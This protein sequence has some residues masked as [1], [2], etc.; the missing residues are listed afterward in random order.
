MKLICQI[1]AWI[2]FLIGGIGWVPSAVVAEE[3]KSLPSIFKP[4]ISENAMV[5]SQEAVATRVGVA[6]LRSGGNAIDAAVAVG[7]VLAVT[8]PRAGNL[9]GGGFMLVYDAKSGETH[10]IDY[11]ETAPE[12]AK[13]DMFLD[14]GGN[15]DRRKAVGSHL[16]VGVPGTVAGLALALDRFGSM[17]LAKVMQPAIELAAKGIS[18]TRD[19]SQSFSPG[20]RKKLFKWPSSRKKFFKRGGL[21]FG[22][23]ETWRQPALA[24]SLK[25]ISEDGPDAFYR[26]EIAKQIVKDMREN[27]GLISAK[28]LEKYKPI[29]RRPVRG[30]YRGYEIA[31][32][33]PPSSGG[34]HLIQ[35]LNVLEGYNFT[36]MGHN[37]AAAVHVAAE[38]MKFAYADRSWYLGD[39]A[40]W[41]VPVAGLTSKAYA[42]EIRKRIDKAHARAADEI[43]PGD[44]KIHEGRNTTHFSI[45]DRHGNVV[46]NTYTLN[47][48]YGSGIVVPGT[49]ILLNNEMD[50]FSAKPGVPNSYGLIGGMANGI[51]PG[52]RPLSSMTPTIVFENGRPFFATGSPGGSRIITT[53]LQVISNIIDHKMNIAAATSA[54]RFHHQ[55]RPD[56][57]FLEPGFSV[58]TIQLLRRKGQIVRVSRPMGSTQSIMISPIGLMGASDP[59]RR[60]ALTAGY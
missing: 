26:G 8:L 17:S 21:A 29:I 43:G 39:P 55:W 51:E 42:R 27:G 37:S 7:F 54:P 4:V 47:L 49:G 34:V 35:I 30:T 32:M 14:N 15:Y 5:S 6:I 13:K 22:I 46:S 2:I 59:R 23:G 52:K 20:R 38:A 45:I 44:P 48:A 19:F 1:V 41:Q 25:L 18:V 31:S 24:R 10:A 36:K 9:G 40:Y 3:A 28:D 16:S 60:G 11:R 53:V 50:D 56:F 12:A 58:D 57:L 33:P